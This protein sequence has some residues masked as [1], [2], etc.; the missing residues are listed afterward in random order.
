M[1]W[2]MYNIQNDF[3]KRVKFIISVVFSVEITSGPIPEIVWN[4]VTDWLVS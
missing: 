4:L 3:K 2:S 1:I